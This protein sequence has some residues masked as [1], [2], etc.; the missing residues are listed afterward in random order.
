MAGRA[1][2]LANE[3]ESATAMSLANWAWGLLHLKIDYAIPMQAF[4]DGLAYA[5]TLSEGH[6]IAHLINGLVCH[7]MSLTGDL[8]DA[9]EWCQRSVSSALNMHYLI[10]ASHLLA[11][12]AVTLARAGLDLDAVQLLRSMMTNGHH[13]RRD[14]RMFM[15]SACP[16]WDHLDASSGPSLTIHQAGSVA[17]GAL[18]RAK[19]RSTAELT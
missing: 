16:G 2:T 1:L 9:I 15:D 8:D 12:T 13:P 17:L 7:V 19:G 5:Q 10:G 6:L 11:A 4:S 14:I 3:T 18:E